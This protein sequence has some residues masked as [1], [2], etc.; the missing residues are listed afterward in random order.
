MFEDGVSTEIELKEMK[1][2]LRTIK[3]K[4]TL[5]TQVEKEKVLAPFNGYVEELSV[6][7]VNLLVR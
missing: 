1:A 7:L 5:L 6:K 4:N 2:I 3:A